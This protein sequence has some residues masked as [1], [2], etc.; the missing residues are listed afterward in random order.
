MQAVSCH[1][2]AG[3]ASAHTA[4]QRTKHF[5]E[6]HTLFEGTQSSVASC[7]FLKSDLCVPCCCSILPSFMMGC[8]H[9]LQLLPTLQF[10]F[11]G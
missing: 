5:S 10:W 1:E 8:N 9:C 7:F 6:M 11:R 4:C 3:I 2:G